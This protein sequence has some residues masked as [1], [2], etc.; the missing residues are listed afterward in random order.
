[1]HFTPCLPCGNVITS[2]DNATIIP[3]GTCACTCK[4]PEPPEPTNIPSPNLYVVRQGGKN[5]GEF[6]YYN[7][8]QAK[9]QLFMLTWKKSLDSSDDEDDDDDEYDDTPPSLDVFVKG[10]WANL[11]RFSTSSLDL[12]KLSKIP[13]E[14]IVKMVDLLMS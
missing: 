11:T 13:S 5:G 4:P 7:E 6:Y 10:K 8:A 1:M 2:P 3:S 14:E 12:T 9:K